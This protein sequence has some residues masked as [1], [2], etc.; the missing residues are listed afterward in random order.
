[1][2]TF[3][4]TLLL[5]LLF[6]RDFCSKMIFRELASSNCSKTLR[7][8]IP[9]YTSFCSTEAAVKNASAEYSLTKY[10]TQKNYISLMYFYISLVYYH[11]ITTAWCIII[12]IQQPG[13]KVHQH[14][15][16]DVKPLNEL[17][18][19]VIPKTVNTS[20]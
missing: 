1:M 2:I 12:I 5:L 9:G 7:A 3:F 6:L 15:K 10:I 18:K 14:Q 4:A 16:A 20:A 8:K 17:K 19:N 13:V 11:H